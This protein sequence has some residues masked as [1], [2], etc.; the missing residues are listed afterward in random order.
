[1]K[2]IT[3]KYY[4]FI[5]ATAF[6]FASCVKDDVKNKLGS[7]GSTYFKVLEAPLNKIFFQPFTDIRTVDLFSL[8]KDAPNGTELSTPTAVKLK[9]DPTLI[10]DYNTANGDSYETLPDSLF[11]L[12]P[13][14]V[15][16]GTS[17][18]TTFASGDFA[19]EFV[20]KLNGAKWNLAHKY[21]VGVSIEDV[22]GKK[23]SADKNSVLVLISIKN[24]WDGVYIASGTMVDV[25][26]PAFT[27]LYDD[28][29]AYGVN[30]EYALTTVNATQCAV[31]SNVYQAGT[32]ANPFW[33]GTTWSYYGSFGLVV[34]FDL[35]TDKITAATNY[36]GQQSGGNKRSA[37]LDPSGLN[38]YDA[39]TKTVN[40]KYYM[41]QFANLSPAPPG[42]IRTKWDETWKFDRDR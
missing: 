29:G 10:A 30:V 8:R 37:D 33:T 5:V 26:N 28:P 42:N 31:V 15:K 39:G 20:I 17:Y 40:I 6:L 38:Q 13:A 34:T 41:L 36:Y 19:K 25:T 11:T 23:I 7:E 32:V 18:T 4:A 14:F 27:G 12:D 2:Y 3:I 24:K 1:M 22:S 21:A 16:A 9:I 35:A